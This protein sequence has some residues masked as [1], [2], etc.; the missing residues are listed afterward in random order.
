MGVCVNLPFS[1]FQACLLDRSTNIL[2]I[3]FSIIFIVFLVAVMVI[4]RWRWHLRLWFYDFRHGN[5]ASHRRKGPFEYDMFV[6]YDSDDREWVHRQLRPT[7][8]ERWGLRLCIH[9]RDFPL[10]R[11]EWFQCHQGHERERERDEERA[12]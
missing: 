10:G 7:V 8:E 1:D 11:L 4:Y 3:G 12:G 2:I 5:P 6:V 9:E